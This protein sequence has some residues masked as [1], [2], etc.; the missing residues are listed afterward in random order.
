MNIQSGLLFSVEGE[1]GK[2]EDAEVGPNSTGTE[3]SAGLMP[4]VT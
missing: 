4:V 2:E 3:T 1:E